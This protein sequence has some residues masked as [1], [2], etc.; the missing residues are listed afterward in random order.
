MAIL[1]SD[2][3]VFLHV[4]ELPSIEDAEADVIYMLPKKG[5]GLFNGCDEYAFDPEKQEFVKI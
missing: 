2:D 4:T 5:S 3:L 1:E